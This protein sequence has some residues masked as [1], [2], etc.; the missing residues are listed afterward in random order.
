MGTTQEDIKATLA[1]KGADILGTV[2]YLIGL[3]DRCREGV[4]QQ[5]AARK[6]L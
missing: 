5:K 1:L 4:D 3:R 6:P 2:D